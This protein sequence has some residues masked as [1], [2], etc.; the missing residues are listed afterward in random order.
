MSGPK[1]CRDADGLAIRLFNPNFMGAD[2]KDCPWLRDA[3]ARLPA[4]SE[5]RPAWAGAEYE[6]ERQML[7]RDKRRELEGSPL[8]AI[9]ASSFVFI[10][11]HSRSG[12]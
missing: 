6:N 9:T 12:L 10:P 11:A 4:V 8:D 5:V 1:P 2:T 7:E 3:V